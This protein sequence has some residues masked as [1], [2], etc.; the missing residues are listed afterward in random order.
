MSIAETSSIVLVLGA[1]AVEGVSMTSSCFSALTEP[2]YASA[3]T[4]ERD[5]GESKQWE[6]YEL[7]KRETSPAMGE[8]M[9]VGSWGRGLS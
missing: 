6:G 2:R 4:G 7:L 9:W 5:G 3:K 8:R 1:A